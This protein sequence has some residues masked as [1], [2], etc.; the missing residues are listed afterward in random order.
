MS[1]GAW[2]ATVLVC[3]IVLYLIVVLIGDDVEGFSLGGVFA[4][5]AHQP[6]PKEKVDAYLT[7]L[8]ASVVA[9]S[10][11]DRLVSEHSQAYTNA[12]LAAIAR[13]PTA[14]AIT[15]AKPREKKAAIAADHTFFEDQ[16]KANDALARAKAQKDLAYKQVKLADGGVEAATKSMQ[17]DIG[18]TPVLLGVFDRLRGSIG[19]NGQ[20]ATSHM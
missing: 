4:Q 19:V 13:G 15:A 3:I 8:T 7:T 9:N 2:F 12:Q 16:R 5:G 17:A 20:K 11:Y 6:T 10:E 1:P 18:A 14:N